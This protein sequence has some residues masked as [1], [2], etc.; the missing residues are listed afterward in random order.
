MGCDMQLV[1]PCD[2]LQQQEREEHERAE[3]EGMVYFQ[4]E[5]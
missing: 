3:G 1:E 4:R 5:K 2:L